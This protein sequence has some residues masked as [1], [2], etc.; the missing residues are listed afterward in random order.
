MV[1]FGI[2]L[3]G[4][5]AR[6]LAH[7]P[8]L[9]ALDEL[10]LRPVCVAGTSIGAVIGVLYCSGKSGREI[11]ESLLEMVP[12]AEGSLRAVPGPRHLFR[13]LEFIT[14]QLDGTGLLKA[15]RFVSLLFDSVRASS[16][17]QLVI[18]LRVVTADFW[19]REEVVLDRGL[20]RPAVQASMSLPGLFSPVVIGDRVLI[21]GGAVNPVP[22]DVLP[23]DCTLTAAVDVLGRRGHVP[24]Q[25]PSLSEVIFNTFQIM[26]KS[27]VRAKL[28][29]A[30]PDLYVE[31]DSV[32]V[33]LL[34]FFKAHQILG[35]ATQAREY[36][37]RELEKRLLE[38]KQVVP[39]SA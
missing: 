9:E 30:R 24:A 1:R 19:S 12:R 26:Q 10:G 20:L 39:R 16:F 14:P 5:G 2:A 4:G 21:D 33:R 7:V 8:M 38:Q 22:F 6:G 3:G 23:P 36:F 37:K 28:R 15:E 27:I 32:D 31:V 25:P 13:W 18:P 35:Q 29:S 17:D 34:E 11:R